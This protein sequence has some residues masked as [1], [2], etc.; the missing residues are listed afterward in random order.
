MDFADFHFATTWLALA[1]PAAGAALFA[2]LRWTELRRRRGLATFAAERLPAPS[3]AV[4]AS[5]ESALPSALPADVVVLNPPRAGV[6]ATGLPSVA[7]R[8]CGSPLSG[9][10][11][12]TRPSASPKTSVLPTRNGA[13]RPR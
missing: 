11:Q 10:S 9:D 13:V 8:S 6:A 3:R 1:A 7:R 4:A 5:V 2:G 12:C